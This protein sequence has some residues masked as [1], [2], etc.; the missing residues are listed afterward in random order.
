MSMIVAIVALAFVCVTLL[1]QGVRRSRRRRWRAERKVR[2]A[3][4]A[5]DWAV[6]RTTFGPRDTRLTYD[7]VEGE[8]AAD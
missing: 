2:H 4:I 6:M 5:R 3:Q 1:V 7:G 8:S